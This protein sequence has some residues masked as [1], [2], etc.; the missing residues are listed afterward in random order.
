MRAVISELH[1]KFNC[2]IFVISLGDCKAAYSGGK[3]G[4][5]AACLDE[6]VRDLDILIIVSA[7]NRTPRKENDPNIEEAVSLYPDYLKESNNGIFEPANALNVLS[8]GSLAHGEGLDQNTIQDMSIHTI[9]QYQEPSPFT[10]KGPGAED[11]IKPDIVDFGG[12]YIFDALIGRL[13]SGKDKASAGVLTLHHDFINQLFVTGSGTSY[14][15]PMVAN[16]ASNLLRAF[17]QASSNL[18][19][20][21]LVGA[22]SNPEVTKNCLSDF[23]SI[24]VMNITGY[25]LIDPEKALFSDE[26]RVTLYAEGSLELDHFAVFQIHIPKE[27]QTVAGKKHINVTLAFN[28]PVRHTRND[29]A[30]VSMSFR[31]IRGA[32]PDLIFDHYRSRTKKEGPIPEMED[33]FDCNLNP[34]ST[35]REKGS[36]Q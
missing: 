2:R 23:D 4:T 6:L 7:G 8:V 29:Y 15:A 5:W 33:K 32:S 27:F 35:V 31:L 11:C 19:R 28:P 18:L 17:P 20:A 22:A 14:S 10:R 30:G 1:A 25:G 13:L 26:S 16:K 9:T 36:L 21:L 24:D 34:P 12:T 3:V